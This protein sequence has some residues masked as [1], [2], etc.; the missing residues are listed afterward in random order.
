MENR[1]EEEVVLARF[2]SADDKRPVNT[3]IVSRRL[4]AGLALS[5]LALRAPFGHAADATPPA[6]QAPVAPPAQPTPAALLPPLPASALTPAPV[7]AAVAIHRPSEAEATQL[8]EVYKKFVSGAGSDAATKALLTKYPEV[9]SFHVLRPTNPAL[10]P[11]LA[12]GYRQKHA[13]NVARIKEGPIELMFMGDSITDNWRT[14]GKAVFEKYYGNIKTAN[15]GIGGDTLQGVLY[16]LRDGEGEGFSP[17]AIMLMIGTNNSPSYFAE[18]IAEGIGAIV[19]D[20]RTRFPAAK[21]LLLGIFPRGDPGDAQRTKVLAV[22]PIIAK[23]HDGK[24]IFYLDIGDKFLAPD[25]TLPT[26]P[27][28][29][30]PNPDGYEIWAAAVKDKLAELMK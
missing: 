6:A 27:D 20:M 12:N 16:R 18:E 15:F 22:N 1:E 10:I 7:P 8:R 24:N 3:P 30:H 2:W 14:Q 19:L 13:N 17:K 29:L 28:K 23:L 25:G 26:F 21:I 4:L 9:I 11:G 5:F